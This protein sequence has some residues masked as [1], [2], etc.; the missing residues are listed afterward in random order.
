MCDPLV[1]TAFWEYGLELFIATWWQQRTYPAIA[2]D[3]SKKKKVNSLKGWALAIQR[4]KQRLSKVFCLWNQK[5]AP[6]QSIF[7]LAEVFLYNHITYKAI[8]HVWKVI[9]LYCIKALGV[10]G[11]RLSALSPVATAVVTAQWLSQ[12]LRLP[13]GLTVAVITI[14]Y[15]LL[16]LPPSSCC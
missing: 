10:C 12:C 11:L 3:F 9:L 14:T 5:M 15:K 1:T 16:P 4:W 7:E 2:T 8:P 6:W 13:A